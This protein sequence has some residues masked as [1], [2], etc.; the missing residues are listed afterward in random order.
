[1]R[2]RAPL[3]FLLVAAAPFASAQEPQDRQGAVREEVVVERVVIDAHVVGSDGNPIPDLV[4]ADFRVKVDGKRVYLESAEWVPADTPENDTSALMGAETNEAERFRTDAPPGR[5]ILMFFQ[6]DTSQSTRLTGL[7]RNALQARLF[8]DTLL[9][10]DRVAVASYDSQLKLRQDFTS[11]RAR[12][13]RAINAAI[14]T[15]PPPESDPASRPSIARYFDFAAA[16]KA[17][18]PERALELLARAVEPIPGGKSMLYFG[19][20]LGTV[21]GLTGPI[22]AERY[23]WNNAISA[24]A[25]ARINIFTLDVADADYHS[26]EGY[27]RQIS[28]ITGGRY[29]KTNVFPAL[30]MELVRKAISGRYVLV[31]VKPHGSTRGDHTIEVELA[32]RKGL[33]FARQYFQD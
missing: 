5:L 25:Q 11:D 28:D 19:W 6:T 10:T 30:A 3:A 33:V 29:E 22:A 24:M 20:G 4:P 13:S 26:L 15:S 21:G 1:M 16:K 31:F 7:M 14:R 32:S 2:R 8:L 18:T 12:L 23:A 17:A 27:L 9:P